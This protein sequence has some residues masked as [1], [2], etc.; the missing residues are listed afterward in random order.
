ML[1]VNLSTGETLAFDLEDEASARKWE[2]AQGRHSFQSKI[3]AV[4]IE[5]RAEGR[6]PVVFACPRPSG[7]FRSVTWSADLVYKG[8]R[9]VREVVHCYADKAE[10]TLNVYRSRRPSWCTVVLSLPGRRVLLPPPR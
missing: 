3:R 4:S 2:E 5:L 9:V 6:E 8:G 7:R 10:I 1:R